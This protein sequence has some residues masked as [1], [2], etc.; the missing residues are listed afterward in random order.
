MA[1]IVRT[2]Y[3]ALQGSEEQGVAVFRGVPFAQPPLGSL[4]FRPPQRPGGWSGVRDATR[5]GAGSFQANRPLAPLL[6]ILIPEQSEDCLFLNV[7]TPAAGDGG[8]RPVLV[9]VHGGAWV[10]GAGSE[11]AYDGTALARRGDVV[12]VTL[13][14]RLG[15]FGFLRGTD[16]PGGRLD[17]SGN[18]GLLDVIAALEWVR[19]E[20]AAFGG[21][22]GN[23]TLMGESAGSVNAA[24]LLT[25]APA[26]G[27]FHKAVLESGS[28]NLTTTSE[29]ATATARQILDELGIAPEQAERLRDVPAQELL[30]AQNALAGR[31]AATSFAPVADGGL[32]PARPFEAIAAGAARGVPLL[33]GTN[34]EEMKLYRFLDPAIDSLDE[35]GLL[36]RCEAVFPGSAPDGTPNAARVIAVYREARA[37][38]G[39]ET[40]PAELWLAISTDQV[41]RAGALKLATL[42]AAHTPQTYVYRFD[43]PASAPDGPQGA[44][45]A[46][47]LPFVFGTLERS[48]IGRLVGRTPATQQ[49]S[50][51]MQDAW[52]AFARS[53]SPRCESL[54]DWPP[55]APPRRATMLL[56]E[57]PRVEDAPQEP[58]RAFWETFI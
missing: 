22:P 54:P 56:G 37:A 19:D 36:R 4:R 20:I 46:L 48:E 25:A 6:G 34:R 3:G 13:N 43:W 41:F 15:A 17:S 27:L 32:L 23:V 14:Y 42:Q 40:T 10:I 11:V 53:G 7:W 50:Q 16:L 30:G 58:E 28:L 51:R 39:E 55:Y 33:L 47:E 35:A 31:S 57:R 8:R 21:D 44:T 38:R 45:H 1:P 9:W 12:V 29:R 24:C 5:F 52:L 2:S 18:E 26:Q 49:L